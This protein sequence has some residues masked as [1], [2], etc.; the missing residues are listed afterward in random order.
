MRWNLKTSSPRT[1]VWPALLPP[2]K[3]ITRSARS[4]SRSTIFPFPSSPHWAPTM[5]TPG[6][7]AS[8][9]GEGARRA[10][11]HTQVAAHHQERVVTDLDQAAHRARANL[12]TQPGEGVGV[13]RELVGGELA[14]HAL[15][16]RHDR[17]ELLAAG[18]RL[19]PAPELPDLAPQRSER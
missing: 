7:D 6:I 3:R 9:V 10:L 13:V 15:E 2:W 5:T 19:A 12:L 16:P 14:H 18:P 17:L 8:S 1:I 11:P 4:A